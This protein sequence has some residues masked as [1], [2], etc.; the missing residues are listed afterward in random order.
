MR[1][2]VAAPAM[3]VQKESLPPGVTPEGC[4][5]LFDGVCNLCNGWVR[6]LI[7][8]DRQARLRLA[9]VQSDAGKA[10]LAACGLPTEEYNTMV[11]LEKGRAY[12]KSTAFLRVVRY[13]PWPWPLL[14]AGLLV[15]RPIRDWLYDRVAL[16]RYA[17]FGRQEVCMVP[18]PEIRNRFL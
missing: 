4:V 17:L 14:S 18:T 11:F 7:A 15:P 8:R 2:P 9:S 6:F 5:V 16:N 13:F 10:I 1:Q 3:E 12:V